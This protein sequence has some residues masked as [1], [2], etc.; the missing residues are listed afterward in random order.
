MH[1]QSSANKRASCFDA[2]WREFFLD[3]DVYSGYQI[4]KVGVNYFMKY[5]RNAIFVSC[6]SLWLCDRA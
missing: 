6:A 5:C 4:S 2:V 1:T 3:A